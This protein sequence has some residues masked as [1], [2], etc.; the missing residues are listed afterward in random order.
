MLPQRLE[1]VQKLRHFTMRFDL[2]HLNSWRFLHTSSPR[3]R[4]RDEVVAEQELDIGTDR[5]GEKSDLGDRQRDPHLRDE[6][7]LH[8][9][10]KWPFFV[11]WYVHAMTVKVRSRHALCLVVSFDISTIL[12]SRME[13][14]QHAEVQLERQKAVCGRSGTSTGSQLRRCTPWFG[15]MKR[16]K[17]LDPSQPI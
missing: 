13:P 15:S 8:H 9:V 7:D 1:Y 11:A 16:I 2:P 4:G 14:S 3:L 12:R 10:I 5:I 17:T 6:R